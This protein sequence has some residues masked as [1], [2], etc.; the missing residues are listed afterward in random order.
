MRTTFVRRSSRKKT[1][2]ATRTS[3]PSNNAK[4][5]SRLS[6]SIMI[7]VAAMNRNT[8]AQ[9]TKTTVVRMMRNGPGFRTKPS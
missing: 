2:S 7:R 5:A 4:R 1:A 9:I 8:A 6:T 3:A